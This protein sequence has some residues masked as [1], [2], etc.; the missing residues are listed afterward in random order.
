ENVICVNDAGRIACKDDLLAYIHP[1]DKEKFLASLEAS[2]AGHGDYTKT[3]RIRLADGTIIPVTDKGTVYEEEG[4]T[5]LVGTLTSPIL[6]TPAS[7]IILPTTSVMGRETQ[8]S[9]DY[10]RGQ[11]LE[12]LTSTFGTSAFQS[13][14]NVLLQV[15][16]DNLPMLMTWYSL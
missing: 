1:E 7:T 3:Y 12:Q 14:N 11:F 4:H 6:Q 13:K 9:S 16:I 2:L 15:S 10:A 8:Y 5:L